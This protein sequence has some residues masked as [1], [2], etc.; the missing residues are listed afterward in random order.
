MAQVITAGGRDPAG[1]NGLASI[2]E[3]T[4]DDG[5][6]VQTHCGQAAAATFLTHC[7]SAGRVLKIFD[8]PGGHWMVAYGFNEEHVYL[9]NWGKMTWD[10]FRRHWD[11]LVP[12]LIQMRLTALALRG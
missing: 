4:N 10:E 1:F 2:F 11:S 7:V 5:E 12:S 3:Y 6:L 8:L 9:S